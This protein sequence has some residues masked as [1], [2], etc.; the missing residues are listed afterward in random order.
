MRILNISNRAKQLRL[1]HVFNIIHGQ[2]PSYLDDKFTRISQVHNYDTRSN[3]HNFYTHKS[4]SSNSGSFY[5][6]SIHDW[7][8]L[9][10]NQEITQKVNFK[11][12]VKEHLLQNLVLQLCN[13]GKAIPSLSLLGRAG[14]IEWFCGWCAFSWV[15]F[16]WYCFMS[17]LDLVWGEFGTIVQGLWWTCLFKCKYLLTFWFHILCNFIFSISLFM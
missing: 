7:A 13:I 5:Q 1:N 9:P 17:C 2:G 6:I 11:K 14:Q 3:T 12:A 4:N 8:D 16:L 10:N 15:G